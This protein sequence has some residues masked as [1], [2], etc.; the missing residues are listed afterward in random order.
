MTEQKPTT[1]HEAGN[2]MPSEQPFPLSTLFRR[3]FIPAFIAFTA[4]FL[5]LLGLTAQHV[6]EEIYL[7][8]AQRRAQT[9]ARAV[10]VAAPVAWGHLMSGQT[11]TEMKKGTDADTL[12]QTFASEVKEMNLPE[13]K[14][15]DHDRRVL[16]A[17]KTDEIGSTENGEALRLVIKNSVPEIVTKE[18]PDGSR[19]YEL[20]V[21][22]FDENHTVQTVFELY[23][24][25]TYL[26]AIL[27]N[28]G[29]PT[30]AVPAG[31]LLVLILAL[32]ALVGRAQTD[33]DQ[34]TNALKELQERLSSFVSETAIGAARAAGQGGAI[35]SQKLETTLFYSDI[36]DFTGYSEQN[37]PEVVVAFLNAVMTLQV[38]AIKKH[39]GDVDKMIGD[40]VL[41]R[42][43]GDDGGKRAVAAARAIQ[44]SLAQGDYPRALGIG[45]HTGPVISGAIGPDDRR[46]FTVIGDAVNIAARL[47]SLA[48]KHEIVVD[49]AL[50]NDDFGPVEMVKVKGRT[51]SVAIR[52][53]CVSG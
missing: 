40:A 42:F 1:T 53:L 49:E 52:R 32:N 20:Y 25:V 8:Q 51:Q 47:C 14:V 50:G 22:V 46:D 36:R 2:A 12:A 38:D 7:E 6:V 26:N 9:M 44:T 5:V 29:I 10:S 45:V 4:I 15:Y 41:A 3:R 31:L 17:T 11:L 21:P 19:Q 39:G 24:P 43:D 16:F 23:E 30:M 34:R 18:F 13:L 35:A 28:A 48:A 37:T 33:I 27:L